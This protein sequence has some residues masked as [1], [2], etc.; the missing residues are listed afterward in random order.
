MEEDSSDGFSLAPKEIRPY[1]FEPLLNQTQDSN[2]S[3]SEDSEGGD[4]KEE[5]A[6]GVIG[7]RRENL[8]WCD[9]ERCQVME[10]NEE[11]LCCHE[12]AP[13][14]EKV[15]V[16]ELKCITEHD[17]FQGNCLNIDALEVSMYEFVDTDGPLDDNEPIHEL[18]RYLAYRRFT[19]WIWHILGK[20]RRKIIPACVVSKIRQT[21]PSESYAGFKYPHL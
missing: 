18:Y 5:N 10:T 16:K 8:A 19:R 12:I 9:C 15:E 3:K 17:G 6:V 2:R 4:L 11:C 13:I 1:N 14:L 20:K 21:F 7:T